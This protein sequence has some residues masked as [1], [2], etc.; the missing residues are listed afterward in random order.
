[1]ANI[2][3]I[4]PI[5]KAFV[6]LA[7]GILAFYLL[8]SNESTPQKKQYVEE[9]VSQLIN[10]VIYI[11]ISKILLK[12]SVF[13]QDPMAVLAYPSG[14]S[15]FYLAVFFSTVTLVYKSKRQKFDVLSFMYAFMQVFLIASFV[16][17][18]IL[19]VWDRNTYSIGYMV[20]LAVLFLMILFIRNHLTKLQIMMIAL[21]GWSVGKLALAFIMPLTM[22]FGYTMAP[23]F[24]ILFFLVC[25]A[26]IIWNHRKEMA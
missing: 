14:S 26:F 10:L 3:A 24:I 13:L 17:E 11:W 25:L 8:V 16:Y 23:W 2:S 6:S 5:V 21:I 12:I 19:I 7:A 20:L 18:F 9:I 4:I 22:V 1:M 15:A